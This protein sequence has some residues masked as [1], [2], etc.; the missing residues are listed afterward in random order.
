LARTVLILLALT[1]VGVAGLRLTT[2]ADWFDCLYLSVIT[3]TTV[4]YGEIIELN[5]AGRWFIMVYLVTSLGVVT[6]SAFTFGAL[7]FS[8]ELQSSWRQQRM[9]AAIEQLSGHYIVCGMGRMGRIICDYLHQRQQAFVVVDNDETRIASICEPLGWLFVVGDATDD[10]TLFDAGIDR[11]QALAAV[12]PTDADNVYVVIS[13][14]M[15]SPT[16][17]II[18]RASSQKA[19]EKLQHAGASRVVSPF[20]SGA[21][22]MA[23]FMLTP[24]VE[25]I[26]EVVDSRGQGLEL[27]DI[28]IHADSPYVGRSLRESDLRAKGVLVV[29]VRKVSGEHVMMPPSHYRLQVG[30]NIFAFGS[31]EAVNAVIGGDRPVDS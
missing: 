2:G 19:V 10:Q 13:A 18:A 26:M 4:G 12:L 20:S 1:L 9:N 14:H 28:Q 17:Q 3:L 30:D 21:V 29:G 23:R 27:A 7:L 25:D 5:S 15:L 24:S 22:K 31:P 16:L 6:Y 8:A 11:A